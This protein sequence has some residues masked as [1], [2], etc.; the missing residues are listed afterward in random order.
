MDIEK[1]SKDL[2]YHWAK[3]KGT[4]LQLEK[5]VARIIRWLSGGPQGR[6]Q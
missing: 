1:M 3:R 2:V 4:L 5:A 6:K